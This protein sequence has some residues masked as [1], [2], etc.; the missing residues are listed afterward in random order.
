MLIESIAFCSFAVF[1]AVA[2]FA[3]VFDFA[4]VFGSAFAFASAPPTLA[5]ADNLTIT[6]ALAFALTVTGEWATPPIKLATEPSRIT[7]FAKLA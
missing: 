4:A 2:F 1:A 6:L 5:V 3:T 7:V